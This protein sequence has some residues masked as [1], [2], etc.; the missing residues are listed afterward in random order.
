MRRTT[1]LP[2]DAK[3]QNHRT[4]NG[5]CA[6]TK[7]EKYACE[8]PPPV[9][10]SQRRHEARLTSH[11]VAQATA[12]IVFILTFSCQHA[13]RLGASAAGFRDGNGRLM[14]LNSVAIGDAF[15]RPPYADSLQ[16]QDYDALAS[17]GFDSVRVL[18]VWAHLE[19][20][21]GVYSESA[22]AALAERIQALQARKLRVI[23]D[24]HQD[25]YG[26]GFVGGDGA[27]AWTCEQEHYASFTPRSPWFLGA[28]EPGVRHCVTQ[29][30]RSTELREA[31]RRVWNE[32]ARRINSPAVIGFEIMNEPFFGDLDM[33][34]F[35]RDYLA[36]LYTD[37]IATVRHHRPEWLAFVQPSVAFNA[38]QGSELPTLRQGNIV[39]APHIYDIRAE[40]GDG[41]TETNIEPLRARVQM[42][43]DKARQLGAALWIGEYGGI[44][45]HQGIG[46]YMRTVLDAADELGASRSHWTY[47]RNA[48]YGSLNENGS[49]KTE[50]MRALVRPRAKAIA[51]EAFSAHAWNDAEQHSHWEIAFTQPAPGA[52]HE[53]A[54]PSGLGDHWLVDAPGCEQKIVGDVAYISGQCTSVHITSNLQFLPN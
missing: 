48:G 13:P 5:V 43:A 25:L 35:E 18:V 30:F 4:V 52:E 29:F 33:E 16:E 31:Y 12:A 46:L 37:V 54:I 26:E 14:Q 28:F 27:P 51:A 21:R 36:P 6:P 10:V 41:F 17:L 22:F 34:R 39:F 49:H 7:R 24:M 2:H 32:V 50:L 9:S 53:I 47:E 19:P 40:S 44:A 23:I 11:R 38:G 1:H 45:A 3:E 42:A 20:E 15:K 8:N